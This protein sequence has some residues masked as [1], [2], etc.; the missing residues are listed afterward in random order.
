MINDSSCTPTPQLAS[1]HALLG[2]R[3]KA[4][5]RTEAVDGHET[6]A[7]QVEAL[8]AET[9]ASKEAVLSLRGTVAGESSHWCS[10]RSSLT[11]DTALTQTVTVLQQELFEAKTA[12]MDAQK[13]AISKRD[14]EEAVRE[15]CECRFHV[16]CMRL[17][18]RSLQYPRA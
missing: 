3:A 9:K 7:S 15:A 14:I 18:V 8:K 12:L 4:S 11:P 16:L 10:G 6:L 13:P 2:P 17:P 5:L 1:I